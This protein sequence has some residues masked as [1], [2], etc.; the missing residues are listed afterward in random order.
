MYLARDPALDSVIHQHVG[1]PTL[2]TLSAA[3]MSA[4][5][6]LLQ[7]ATLSTIYLQNITMSSSRGTECSENLSCSEA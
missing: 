2:L 3:G 7:S 5:N 4:G 1:E 6:S